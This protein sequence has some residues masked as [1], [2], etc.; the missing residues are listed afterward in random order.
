MEEVIL[1]IFIHII[2]VIN[3]MYWIPKAIDYLD[4]I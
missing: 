2:V 3:C 4:N 1:F